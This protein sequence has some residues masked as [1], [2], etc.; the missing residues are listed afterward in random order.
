MARS[1]SIGVTLPSVSSAGL[2]SASP[3]WALAA[4]SVNITAAVDAVH[5]RPRGE[6]PEWYPPTNTTVDWT[7]S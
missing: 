6:R 5:A 2:P 3:V 4:A 1:P 7:S